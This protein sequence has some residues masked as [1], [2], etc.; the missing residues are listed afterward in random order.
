MCVFFRNS[1]MKFVFYRDSRFSYGFWTK[2]AIFSDP[3]P[4]FAFSSTSL[5]TF[6]F[7][8][9]FFTKIRVFS[10]F[11]K[12]N[13]CFLLSFDK[14]RVFFNDSLMKSVFFAIL[15]EICGVG[16]LIKFAFFT[17]FWRNLRVFL[18]FVDAIC[19]SFLRLS[20]K[21]YFFVILER[22]S[23]FFNLWRNLCFSRNSLIKYELF[24]NPWTKFVFLFRSFDEIY[25]F[26]WSFANF[27]FFR[28][29]TKFEFSPAI[30]KQIC[31]FSRTFEEI[32]FCSTIF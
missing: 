16:F 27:A 30:F 5:M 19:I 3:L 15:D 10:L 6:T 21:F 23:C 32:W 8:L 14:I 12:L 13:S 18:L 29:L 25:T 24:R 11:L 4:K 31:V 28:Y 1:L 7:S 2:F 20:H 22:N 17:I 26:L 9:W